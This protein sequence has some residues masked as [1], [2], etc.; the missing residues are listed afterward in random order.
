M[1]SSYNP[2]FNEDSNPISEKKKDSIE[3]ESF[4]EE[5]K[6]KRELKSLRKGKNS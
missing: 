1:Y 4:P 6:K 3:I 5:I 2:H